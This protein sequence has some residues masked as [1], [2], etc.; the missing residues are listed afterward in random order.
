MTFRVIVS[1]HPASR[2]GL[3]AVAPRRQWRPASLLRCGTG[4]PAGPRPL[5]LVRCRLASLLAFACLSFALRP[6]ARTF[7]RVA[8]RCPTTSQ[9]TALRGHPPWRRPL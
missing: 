5:A 8:R 6:L 1:R 9:R 2:F 3:R 4:F 7:A